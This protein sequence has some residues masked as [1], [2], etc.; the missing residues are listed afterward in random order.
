MHFLHLKET[1]HGDLKSPNVLFD[2]AG[3]AK[4]ADFGTSRWPQ[5]TN[6]TGLA[7]HTTHTGHST[8]MSFAWAAPEVLESKGT[9]FASDVYSFGIVMW[10]VL[11]RK[12]PWADEACPR[13]IYARVVFKGDRPEIPGGSPAEMARVMSACWAGVENVRPTF[14]DIMKW[15][16]WE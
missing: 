14:S 3:R 12:L 9:S 13:D 4:I 7:T 11:S 5:L 6:S 8:Q 2:G 1:V 15:Q 10:E 16:D